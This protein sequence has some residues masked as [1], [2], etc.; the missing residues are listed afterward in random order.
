ME[1]IDML[2][3][4]KWK[5]MGNLGLFTPWL[6]ML[7]QNLLPSACRSSHLA[8][9]PIKIIIAPLAILHKLMLTHKLHNHDHSDIDKK[10]PMNSGSL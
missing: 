4:C 6:E 3:T 7:S 1:G 5:S 2:C 9:N 8:T 10:K